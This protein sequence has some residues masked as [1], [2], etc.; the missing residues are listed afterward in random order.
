VRLGGVHA[1]P[2]LMEEFRLGSAVGVGIVA[3]ENF[4]LLPDQ[5]HA[6]YAEPHHDRRQETE[7]KRPSDQSANNPA[8]TLSH[9]A[10]RISR[11]IRNSSPLGNLRRLRVPNDEARSRAGFREKRLKGFELSTFCMAIREVIGELLG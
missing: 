1:Q 3:P 7:Q 9:L 6:L 5:R 4:D 10:H 8:A 2:F 11:S